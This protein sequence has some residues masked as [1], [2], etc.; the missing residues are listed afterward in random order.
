MRESAFAIPFVMPGLILASVFII[1][2]MLLTLRLSVSNYQIVKGEYTFIGLNNF[3]ELFLDPQYRILYAYRNNLLYALVTIPFILFFGLL[4]ATMIN[5]LRSG[6]T[7][8][9]VALYLPVITPWVIIG[10]VFTYLFNSS[11]RGLVNYIIVDALHISGNYIPWLLREWTGNAVIWLMGIWKNIGW[12]MV[13][14][15]AALQG[16]S[17]EY[18]ESAEIDGAS[19]AKMFWRIT[20][21]LVKPTTFFILVNMLIGSFNVFLQVLQLTGGNPS[22][23]TSTLQYMLYDKAF[24]LF[25]F[26]QGAAIG[27]ITGLSVFILTLIMNRLTKQEDIV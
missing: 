4:L 20:L 6:R 1:Y 14:Y 21:P 15:L 10:L 9:R 23:R 11:N 3:K 2:P 22:G 8:F 27:L 19:Q 18:Y 12:S 17:R 24:N 26:G 7:F 25:E 16:L 5:N 13:I